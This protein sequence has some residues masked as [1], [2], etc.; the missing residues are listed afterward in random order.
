MSSDAA[1]RL[2]GLAARVRPALERFKPLLLGAAILLF[3][4]GAAISIASLG[5]DW[6]DLELVQIALLVLVLVPLGLLYGT[7]NMIVMARGAGIAISLPDALRVSCFAQ[8]AEFLPLPGGALVRGGALM[9]YGVPTRGAAA[10]VIVNAILWI[11][12]GAIAAGIALAQSLIVGPVIGTIGLAGVLLCSWWLWRNS[13]IGIALAAVG[14]RLIGL[15]LTGLRIS[16]AFLALGTALPLIAVY[17]FA[18]AA[19]LGS[20]S[21]LAPGGLGISE[22]LAA[23]FA[24]LSAVA[25][26]AAFLAVGADRLAGLLVSGLAT[27]LILI[28]QPLSRRPSKRH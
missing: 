6:G 3:L 9:R 20:A 11:S 16:T 10:H 24:S 17:P 14:V 19:I 22:A 2:A 5:L 12:C 26:G 21:S 27:F 23:A 8:L 4:G 1:S 28:F 25:P 7:L 18:F 13:T 15:L